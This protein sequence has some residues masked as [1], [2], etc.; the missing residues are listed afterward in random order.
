MKQQYVFVDDSGDP[1]LVGSNTS[2][3]VIAAVLIEDREKLLQLS[4]AIDGSRAGLGWDQLDEFKFTKT[5]KTILRDL[6]CYVSQFTFAAHAIVVDK[7]K[8]TRAKLNKNESIYYDAIKELLLK[9]ELHQS[10]IVIDG[11]SHRKHTEKI[12]TYLRQSLRQNGV[13]RCHVAFSDSRKNPIIQLADLIAGSVARSLDER[14]T[15]RWDYLKLLKPKNQGI[16][17]ITQ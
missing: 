10:N 2:H 6:L 14:K 15:D 11:A 5:R 1:G 13:S 16:Y 8:M 4:T 3:L 12:R 9:L 7:T 17:D